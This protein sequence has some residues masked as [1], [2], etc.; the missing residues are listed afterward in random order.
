MSFYLRELP[1]PFS[2]NITK[3]SVF[4]FPNSLLRERLNIK[5]HQES[6]NSFNRT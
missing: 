6:N 2:D 3:H 5:T 1:L 4:A